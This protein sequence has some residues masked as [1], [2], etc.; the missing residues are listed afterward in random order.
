MKGLFNLLICSTS[1]SVFNVHLS[2]LTLT[3][4]DSL[5]M[6]ELIETQPEI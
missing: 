3:L 6:L 4:T 5:N 1:L 2:Q